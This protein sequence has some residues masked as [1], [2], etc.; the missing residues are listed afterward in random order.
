MNIDNR[1][2][3]R[4]LARED[5]FASLAYKK[6]GKVKNI[7]MG[8]LAFEYVNITEDSN[9]VSSHKDTFEPLQ[10]S[11]FLSKSKFHL[12]DVPCDLIY[13]EIT[14]VSVEDQKF[15]ISLTLRCCGLKFRTL[16]KD[17][18]AKLEF[19]LNNHT[20]ELSS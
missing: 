7:S 1:K 11:I 5:T 8:G 16:S 3:P 17:I 15:I 6:I 9:Q 18:I 12:S 4:F 19:F 10:L 14:P 13:D 2:H 20:K